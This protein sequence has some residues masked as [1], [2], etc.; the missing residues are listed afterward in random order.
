MPNEP[1]LNMLT[2]SA[3]DLRKT[4][5]VKSVEFDG[6]DLDGYWQDWH[7]VLA[8]HR[9][10]KLGDLELSNRLLLSTSFKGYGYFVKE[11]TT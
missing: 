9:A 7:K 1:P 6:E 8:S 11:Q 3:N 10:L 4:S 2:T 5:D